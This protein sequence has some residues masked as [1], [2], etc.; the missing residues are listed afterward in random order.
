MFKNLT[1]KIY[2][3]III[4]FIAATGLVFMASSAFVTYKIFNAEEKW[5]TYHT[6]S[7]N[8]VLALNALNENIGYGGMVQYFKTYIL[9]KENQYK[10]LFQGSIGSANAALMQYERS[11]ITEEELALVNEI[12]GVV[13]QYSQKFN[14]AMAFVK[15]DKATVDI[16][17]IATTKDE[18]AINAIAKLQ[19]I[20]WNLSHT[21][22]ATTRLELLAQMRQKMGFGGAIHNFK[23]YIIRQEDSYALA[24]ANSL[25]MIQ[26]YVEKYKQFNLTEAEAKAIEVVKKTTEK[27]INKLQRAKKLMA[28]GTRPE[29]AEGQLIVDD[30]AALT[31]FNSLSVEIANLN[32]QDVLLLNSNLSE[33]KLYAEIIIAI[34]V[35]S[36]LFLI[37]VI[38]YIMSR[39]IIMPIN[40]L[41]EVMDKLSQNQLD[42][43]VFGTDRGDEIGLMSQTVQIFKDNAL[44]IQAF[45]KEKIVQDALHKNQ[46]EVANLKQL[47]STI[48]SVNDSSQNLKTLDDLSGKVSANGQLIATAAAEL[49]SGID[50]ISTN[51]EGAAADAQETDRTVTTG[52]NTVQKVDD[53][54]EEISQ[55]VENSVSSLDELTNASD[56]ISK[57]IEV[58]EGISEQTNLLALNATIEAAR[59]GEAGRGFAVVASEVKSLAQQT[60][61]AT[62]DISQRISALQTG[63]N[64]I[65]QTLESSRQAVKGGK[66]SI[67][68]TST[69]MNQAVEQVANVMHRMQEIT[70]ILSTQK[71][72]SEEIANNITSV[73]DMAG[74]SKE[75]VINVSHSIIRSN[76]SILGSAQE[77]FTGETVQSIC[78]MSKLD[79]VIFKKKVIDC[80]MGIGDL[81]EHNY[82]EFNTRRF[83]KWREKN[84]DLPIAGLGGFQDLKAIQNDIEAAAK[85]AIL[86]YNAKDE[87]TVKTALND[88]QAHGDKLMETLDQLSHDI[89]QFA[90]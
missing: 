44:K 22:G 47:A 71:I 40:K 89:E 1:I 31:A 63:M 62:E 81:N 52:Q 86:A 84:G 50:E 57:I 58:I 14:I 83:I 37:G 5:E 77:W 26:Q 49:V 12:R 70:N 33:A 75:E 55:T 9:R 66:E 27:Y 79:H 23:N 45:E 28:E 10:A 72:A 48:A 88:L 65:S 35:I 78:E 46:Q 64:N 21:D 60:S 18:V 76:E 74:E 19:E 53:A 87:D 36:A 3:F 68:E 38:G 51:A 85:S 4:G 25:G 15:M 41:R 2:G 6:N 8:R 30:E 43:E 20:S 24:T 90:A 61:K 82:L 32:G 11:G 73:A 17:K 34:S 56:E 7:A 54:I 42:T 29:S 80:V 69:T 67:R 59:A 16:D 39:K 13:R